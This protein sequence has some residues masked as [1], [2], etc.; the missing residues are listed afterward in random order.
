MNIVKKL[1]PHA[2]VILAG[3]FIIF[4]VIEKFNS[5]MTLLDNPIAKNLLLL[6]G[7]V[8]VIVSGML[9]YRQRRDS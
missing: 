2:C 4:C 3:M 6:F 1:L 7:I 8:A 5:A 9:I